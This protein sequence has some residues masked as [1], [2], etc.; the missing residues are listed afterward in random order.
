LCLDEREFF[1]PPAK[2]DIS[3][4]IIDTSKKKSDIFLYF[5]LDLSPFS[6]QPNQQYPHRLLE[7]YKTSKE[8]GSIKKKTGRCFF[9]SFRFNFSRTSPFVYQPSQ[10]L[11]YTYVQ[12][13]EKKEGKKKTQQTTKREKHTSFFLDTHK[14]PMNTAQLSQMGIRVVRA[15]EDIDQQQQLQQQQQQPQQPQQPQQQQQQPQ[16]QKTFVIVHAYASLPLQ[17]LCFVNDKRSEYYMDT[18]TTTT[19]QEGTWLE[20]YFQLVEGMESIDMPKLQEQAM[21]DHEA[22]CTTGMCPHV[23]P[24]TLR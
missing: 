18:T 17:E 3:I 14:K 11:S 9:S 1:S 8:Q 13:K 21:A 10:R 15:K 24:A 20:P 5:F 7:R 22:G 16:Q 6:T 2:R 19:L 12:D 4:I 23:S